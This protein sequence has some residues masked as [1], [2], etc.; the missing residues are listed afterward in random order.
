MLSVETVEIDGAR[1]LDAISFDLSAGETLCIIGESGSGKTTLLKALA[2]IDAHLR[3]DNFIMV[4]R[5]MGRCVLMAQETIF[6]AC[7]M[8]VG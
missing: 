2:R 6:W 7:Q 5:K 8:S 4:L 3:R 1:L